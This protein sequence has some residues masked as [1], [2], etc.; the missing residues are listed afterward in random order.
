MN[1]A[2][3]AIGSNTQSETT[4]LNELADPVKSLSNKGVREALGYFIP[5]GGLVHDALTGAVKRSKSNAIKGLQE[6]A[7]TDP[8][9]ARSILRTPAKGTSLPI[10]P[11]LQSLLQSNDS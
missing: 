7:L 1:T 11:L 2:G 10:N 8:N 5:G 9:I 3:R 4:L 6:R